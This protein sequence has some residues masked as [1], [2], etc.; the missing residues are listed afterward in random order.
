MQNWPGKPIFVLIDCLFGKNAL[1]IS[2]DTLFMNVLYT[3]L[4][5]PDTLYP[6]VM[7]LLQSNE[8]TELQSVY[9]VCY[10]YTRVTEICQLILVYHHHR[11]KMFIQRKIIIVAGSRTDYCTLCLPQG[12]SD[13]IGKGDEKLEGFTW[14]R[15]TERVTTGIWAWSKVFLCNGPDGDEVR[16]AYIS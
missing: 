3:Y 2:Q 9:N 5:D 8:L 13:W 6:G 11:I 14:R 4:N 15:G 12:S 1:H 10:N 16:L 7:F